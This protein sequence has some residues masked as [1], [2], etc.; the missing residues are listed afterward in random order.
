MPLKMPSAES[1]DRI[2]AETAE[3]LLACCHINLDDEAQFSSSWLAISTTALYAGEGYPLTSQHSIEEYKIHAQRCWPLQKNLRLT[4]TNRPTIGQ[5][6]LRAGQEVLECWKFS[7]GITSDVERLKDCFETARDDL[8][9]SEKSALKQS[10][11]RESPYPKDSKKVTK[12]SFAALLRV[13]SFAGPYWRVVAIGTVLALAT[14]FA[15]LVPP[16]LTMPLVDRVLIPQ[17]SGEH[18]TIGTAMPYLA[19]LAAAAILASS[20]GWGRTW[21]L[22]WVS[23]RITADM[24]IR[25]YA[26]VQS[27]SLDF[28]AT[29]RTGDLISRIGSDTERLNNYV[30]I[31]LIDFFSNLLLVVFTAIVLFTISPLLAVMTLVP[32]PFVVWL[33]Y[34][35]RGRLHQGFSRSRIAWADMTSVLADTIPGIR[36]VK[37]FAQEKREISRFRRANHRVLEANDHVNVTWSYFGPL[38]TLFSEFGILVIWASGV[39]LVFNNSVTVGTLTAFLAY[40]SRFYGKVE[41]M[42]RMVPATQRAAASAQRICDL[43]D[44]RP[45]VAEPTAP[46]QIKQFKGQIDL[47]NIYFR[48]GNREVIH[49]LNLTIK[50]GEMI[51]LVG[52]SGAGKTTLANLICRFHDPSSGTICID[53]IDLRKLALNN[54]RQHIGCVLQE[55]FLFFGSIAENISYGRPEAS[56]DEIVT[57]ARAAGAHDFILRLPHAYD[58]R[59]GERG[60]QLSGGERQRISIAR[61]LLVNPAI[62]ILDEATSSVDAETESVIQHAIEELVTGRT[63]IAIAHRLATLRR[64]DR[65]VVLE[66]GQIVEIGTHDELLALGRTYA[67]LYQTQIIDSHKQDLMAETLYDTKFATKEKLFE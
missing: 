13:L 47:Q 35:V 54:Y 23:E 51:G 38:V 9:L 60:A 33:V 8:F 24:R 56:R 67:R 37:A 49:G 16:Y 64:A 62:L 21:I 61:A 34:S 55:P 31:S 7:A 57:A 29:H 66:H 30:S 18:V 1:F 46:H 14:T 58:S 50:A 12:G 6:E 48:Y 59:V 27:L 42:V 53:G 3:T 28:F 10:F 20:L 19:G 11:K 26:H 25:T 4:M 44:C 41:S 32:F 65:L 45:T 2:G 17:Q 43:L 52:T 5:L 22:A 15:S 39:W 63:T 36:V 40:I